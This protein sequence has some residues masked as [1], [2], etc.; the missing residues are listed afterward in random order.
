MEPSHVCPGEN[1]SQGAAN[2]RETARTDR[3]GDLTWRLTSEQE[4]V[5]VQWEVAEKATGVE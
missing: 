2:L 5:F 3:V 4:A 1:P